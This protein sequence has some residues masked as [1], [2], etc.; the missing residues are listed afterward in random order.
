MLRLHSRLTLKSPNLPAIPRLLFPPSKRKFAHVANLDYPKPQEQ[1]HGFTLLRTKHVPEL[2]LT[3]FHLTHNMTGANLLHVARNDNNNV[4]SIGFKTNPPD[5]TGVP[6]ILE[7][8]TLCGSRKFPIRDPFFKMLPRSLS[9]FMNAMTYPDHTIYPFATTNRKDF[10]NL[11]SVYLDSTLHPLL[12]RNDFLQEGWRLAPEDPQEKDSKLVFKG[13]VY[14]EMKGVMSDPDSEFYVQFN[15]HIF[16]AIN[17]SGGDPKKITDL[18]YERLKRF[19][20]DHYHPSNAKIVTYGDMPLDDH[21]KMISQQLDSFNKIVEDSE[22]KLPIDLDKLEPSDRYVSVPG[23][24]D[25]SMPE[26]KQFKTSTSWMM[27]DSTN[28]LEGF[29]LYVVS[30]LLLAGQGPL[31]HALIDSGLGLAFSPNTG[32]DSSAKI[33]IFSVGLNGVHEK[34]VPKVKDTIEQTLKDAVFRGF[35]REKVDGILHQFELGLRHKSPRFGMNIMTR[36]NGD[37]FRGADPFDG[38]AHEEIISAFKEKYAEEGYLENLV[39]KYLL[40]DKSFTFT[41]APSEIFEQNLKDEEASRLNQKITE[42][43]R[44]G[45][46]EAIAREKLVNQEQELQKV[47]EAARSQDVSCLPT[48][49]VSDIPR[50]IYPK[51]VDFS[52]SLNEFKVQWRETETNGLTYF[53]ALHSLGNIPDELR[54][55]IPIFAAA[56]MKVD[57]KDL[58]AEQLEDKIRLKTGGISLGYHIKT[59]PSDILTTE[60]E[61]NFSGYALSQNIPAMFNL[62]KSMIGHTNF[63]DAEAE[64]KIE[65]LIQ[66]I[67]SG[68]TGTIAD[69]GHSYAAQYAQAGLSPACRAREIS[70]GLTFL[71]YVNSL[72]DHNTFASSNMMKKLQ[73]LQSIAQSRTPAFRVALT[74]DAAERCNAQQH[75]DSFLTPSQNESPNLSSLSTSPVLSPYP[76]FPAFT[77]PNTL[78]KFPFQVSYAAHAIRTVPYADAASAPLTLL[79]QLL[80]H[81]HLHHEI[82]EKGGAYGASAS[83]NSILGTF[84]YSSYRDPNP[85]NSLKVM[86]ESGEWVLNETFTDRDLEEAKL[87][88]FTSVDAPEAV[89][90]E[91]MDLF[92][93]G[94]TDE[95]KQER[96]ERILDTSI[97]DIKEAAEKYI[98]RPAKGSERRVMIGDEAALSGSEEEWASK[99]LGELAKMPKT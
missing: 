97:N 9:N 46:N 7:H 15:D 26:D 38:L 96:R 83:Y 41:M 36:I 99:T 56:A 89:N 85:K 3:A 76:T 84:T 50:K 72:S 80:T 54:I 25:P 12:S 91:G 77:T 88:V 19:H 11:L 20:A 71:G 27:G 62:F 64:R 66:S 58:T 42:A 17:N 47:Q 70:S 68:A 63:N 52:T 40:N 79:S 2:Q 32:Y 90:N 57:G 45:P 24:I 82:R 78:I 23:P 33:G 34:D 35:E 39:I 21:L 61:L 51:P 75:L 8:T 5:D 30:E 10:Q 74:C 37:W 59:S 69:G 55:L 67:A 93:L 60:D 94:L 53:R 16:P 1:L 31:Y 18:T 28:V 87:S 73:L 44:D 4:F 95:M 92:S 14:N 86:K 43:I 81:K 48:L 22:N 6:H 29:S 65:L 98:R 13:V 49:H